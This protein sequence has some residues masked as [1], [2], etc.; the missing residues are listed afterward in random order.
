MAI[1]ESLHNELPSM[2]V[3]TFTAQRDTMQWK[4][5]NEGVYTACSI[6]KI[7]I[8]FG[9][10]RAPI[11]TWKLCVPPTV[12][13]FIHFLLKG[14]ILTQDVMQYR[15]M[16]TDSGCMMCCNCPVESAL[17]LIFLCPVATEV[18]F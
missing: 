10:I 11:K 18:W 7:M 8:G 1:R 3:V 16:G 13:I 14:K 17:H 12:R 5:T 4:W 2:Q 6:Y 9:K 15:K